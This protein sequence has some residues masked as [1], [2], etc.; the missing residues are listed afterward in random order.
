MAS[1]APAPPTAPASL[2]NALVN[3]GGLASIVKCKVKV[4]VPCLAAARAPA[5]ALARALAT[6][7]ITAAAA[8]ILSAQK[9]LLSMLILASYSTAQL[10][11]RFP[12]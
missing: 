3:K 9:R 8:N 4:R 7:A 2:C 5:A 10:I 11:V 6:L 12:S 1:T